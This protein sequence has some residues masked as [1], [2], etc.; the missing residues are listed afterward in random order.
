MKKKSILLL[1]VGA[2]CIISTTWG[3]NAGRVSGSVQIEA[4]TSHRD[5]AI[6]SEDVPSRLLLNSYADFRYDNGPF[7]AGLRFEAYHNP[8]LGFDPSYKGAGLA[9]YFFSYQNDQLELTA[10]HYYEQFGQGLVLRAYED[11]LLG[12]DNALQGVRLKYRPVKG[13]TLTGLI[14]RQRSAWDFGAGI[15][16]GLDGEM[17]LNSIFSTL[18][19]SKTRVNIGLSF[20][21]RF[22]DDESIT[23]DNPAYMLNL[24]LNV[25]AVSARMH[26]THG[27]FSLQAEYAGKGQD[28]NITNGYIYKYGSAVLLNTQYARPGFSA[29]LRA[30]RVDN[31]DFRSVRSRSGDMLHINY[32]PSIAQPHSYTFFNLYPYAT[33]T[34]GELGI[35]GNLYF[36]LRKGTALGGKYGTDVHLNY[37]TISSLDTMRIG[38]RGT[39]GYTSKPIG[40]NREH[41]YTDLSIELSHKF[42]PTVKAG[43]CAGYIVFNPIVEGHAGQLHH[44]WVLATDVTLKLGSRRVLRLEAEWLESDSKYDAVVDDK[45]CGDWLMEVVEYHFARH[46][47]VQ[48]NL[49]RCYHDG[50]GNYNQVA[51]GYTHNA[52]RLQVGYG[53]QRQGIVCVGGVCREMPA[54][55]G[56]T[57]SFITSF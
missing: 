11:R 29:S 21:S 6:G 52:S 4:Q 8:L 20:V 38:G 12:L 10:G 57:V 49:Q 24:P 47:F 39:D 3:Q 41:Y 36:K 40:S 25:G 46:F 30:Q 54:S 31:M 44:N 53:R 17:A 9:H 2:L 56:L 13:I 7:S 33:Q 1:A 28:P 34:N 22:E 55:N 15:V 42:S 14:G 23:S 50:T 51:V 19:E 43:F 35:Q 32:I 48:A 18:S 45:R 26:M 16:R 5:T 37:T 27:H